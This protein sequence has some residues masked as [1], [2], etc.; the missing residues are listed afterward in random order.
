MWLLLFL[1]LFTA[2]WQ[3]PT[4]APSLP[5]PVDSPMLRLPPEPAPSPTDEPLCACAHE[6]EVERLPGLVDDLENIHPM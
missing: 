3:M 4:A 5:V 1:L 2:W 6:D